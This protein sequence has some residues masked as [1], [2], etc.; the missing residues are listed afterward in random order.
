MEYQIIIAKTQEEKEAIYKFRYKIYFDELKKLHLPADHTNK[1]M[2]DEADEY[3]ALYYA[4]DGE[5]IIAT[6]RAIRGVDGA[7]LKADIDFFNIGK[8]EEYFNHDE[9]AVV[10]RLI[11]DKPYR[12]TPLTNELMLATYFG[13]LDVGTKLCFI[14]C[15]SSLLGFYLK[16][17]FRLF[18][19]PVAIKNNQLRYHLVL[20]LYDLAHLKKVNSPF[21]PHLPEQLNDH[22]AYARKIE[23]DVGY[24]LHLRNI[25]LKDRIILLITKA[26]I[27]IKFKNKA[28]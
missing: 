8:F 20:I 12:H 4:K 17:G 28:A 24:G 9:I 26:I 2:Y 15:D 11:I 3:C 23:S 18:Q 14:T 6:V 22:G 21:V 10:N 19:N 7:F 5:N 27:K 16:Y 13:G 1:Q 25:P